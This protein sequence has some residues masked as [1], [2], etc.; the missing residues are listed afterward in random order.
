MLYV[1]TRNSRETYTA[2]RA[3]H[4]TY[5]PDGGEFAPFY[6]PKFTDKDLQKM[7]DQGVCYT[8]A[9]VLNLFF[10]SRI[11]GWDVECLIGRTPINLEAMHHK[12]VIAEAWRNPEGSYDYLLRCLYGMLLDCDAKT[13]RPNGWARIAIEIALI[14]GIYSVLDGSGNGYHIAITDDDYSEFTSVIY[15]KAMGLPIDFV[16]YTSVENNTL[17]DLLNRG[18]FLVANLNLKS[19]FV[20][21]FETF[22]YKMFGPEQVTEFVN[23]CANKGLFHILDE[24]RI[25][26]ADMLF[27]VVI[28]ADRIESV[29]SSIYRSNHYDASVDAAISF[30]GLQDYRSAT[31]VSKDTLILSKKRPGRTRE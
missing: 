19:D 30:S 10:G 23:A 9:E 27:S 24:Q 5:A 6:L 26:L 31:G 22:V 20:N 14:F 4:E 21:Y 29:V 8:I 12:L 7:R 13:K 11:S 16:V 15:A 1:S 28:S 17:W 18:E 3:L 2:H 25:A